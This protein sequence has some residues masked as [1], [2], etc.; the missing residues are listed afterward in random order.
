MHFSVSQAQSYGLLLFSA[1][2]RFHSSHSLLSSGVCI[3]LSGSV[4]I[5]CMASPCHLERLSLTYRTSVNPL[6]SRA[7][8][9]LCLPHLPRA[10]VCV[11]CDIP[12]E[13][14]VRSHLL[15]C[16]FTRPCVL[17]S[18]PSPREG[19]LAFS[20]IVPPS[21][22]IA[23]AGTTQWGTSLSPPWGLGCTENLL[24]SIPCV[25]H[26]LLISCLKSPMTDR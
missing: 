21:E 18:I 13:H 9:Q 2:P 24:L 4:Y 3:Y 12:R 26:K 5:D 25:C 22:A 15:S 7:A 14:I 11:G 6:P 1:S 20:T 19:T 16:N 8:A 10:R 23:S 17:S